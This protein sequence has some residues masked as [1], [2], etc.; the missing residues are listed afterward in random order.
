M[1]YKDEFYCGNTISSNPSLREKICK[2][3]WLPYCFFRYRKETIA[4]IEKKIYFHL[5]FVFLWWN[6]LFLELFNESNFFL[7]YFHTRNSRGGNL[8]WKGV[9]WLWIN[10]C[11]FCFFEI[12]LFIRFTV[13]TI[14]IVILNFLQNIIRRLWTG[15]ANWS[16]KSS[17]F[18]RILRILRN[19]LILL[20]QQTFCLFSR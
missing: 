2:K 1:C 20:S 6:I 7:F 9:I 12:T 5:C 17:K 8:I 16:L 13:D 4:K 14:I 19:I 15:E 10:K 18:L 11:K 3:I